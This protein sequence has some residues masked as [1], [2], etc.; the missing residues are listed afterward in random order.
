MHYAHMYA[1]AHLKQKF[2]EKY[3]IWYALY[4]MLPQLIGFKTN[5]HYLTV[6]M[7]SIA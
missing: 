6:C 5:K 7:K 3:C 2:Q 4:K 1:Y